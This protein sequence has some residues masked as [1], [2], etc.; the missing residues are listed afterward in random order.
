MRIFAIHGCSGD[1][2][3]TETVFQSKAM[4][5]MRRTEQQP[6]ASNAA[7]V[8]CILKYKISNVNRLAPI[9]AATEH[10]APAQHQQQSNNRGD[11]ALQISEI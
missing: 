5:S 10:R 6:I 2:G 4:A 11:A 9:N 7:V 1:V 3:N 8:A